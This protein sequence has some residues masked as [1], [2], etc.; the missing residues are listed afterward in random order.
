MPL[1]PISNTAAIV[2]AQSSGEESEIDITELE[3]PA[4]VRSGFESANMRQAL[5]LQFKN[6]AQAENKGGPRI[7]DVVE[8]M[9]DLKYI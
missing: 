9:L 6:K 2:S 5:Q 8:K 7:R 4:E 1:G 3:M